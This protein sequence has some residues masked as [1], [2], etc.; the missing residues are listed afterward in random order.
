MINTVKMGFKRNAFYQNKFSDQ[1]KKTVH[2]ISVK[3]I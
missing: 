1:G 2:L 3:K